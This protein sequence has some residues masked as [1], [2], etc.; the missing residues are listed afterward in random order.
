MIINKEINSSLL[1]SG[2]S[3]FHP[4]A[5]QVG[6][7]IYVSGLIARKLGQEKIPGVI[8]NETGEITGHDVTEQFRAIYENLVIILNEA[9]SSIEKVFDVTVFLT[10]IKDDFK[11]FNVVYG[12]L[13]GKV[14]PCRT[15]IEVSKFPS[16]V[17]IEIKIIALK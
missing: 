13:L 12:E 7:F 9:G 1:P 14:N 11:K 5:R 16:P 6:D 4:H 2:V 15:T 10:N 17:C 3:S 8:Y